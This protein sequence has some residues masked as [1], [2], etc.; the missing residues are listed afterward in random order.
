[1]SPRRIQRRRTKG[2]R[3]PAGAVY[4]GR[5]SRW[6]NPWRAQRGSCIGPVWSFATSMPT[7]LRTLCTPA[8]AVALYSSHA[9]AST[10]AES[11]VAL[12]RTYCQVMARDHAAEFT[13]WLEP[14]AGRDLMCWCALDQHCHADV[15]LEIANTT[16]ETS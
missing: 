1:M 9:P 13:E 6:G 14:L 8:V 12:F 16:Q 4:V 10:A 2:W 7:R 15:L 5:G 3:K 11:A